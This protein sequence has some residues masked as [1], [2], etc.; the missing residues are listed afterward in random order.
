MCKTVNRKG[1]I[2]PDAALDHAEGK[3]ASAPAPAAPTSLPDSSTT[4][5]EVAKTEGG[6]AEINRRRASQLRIPGGV[7]VPGKSGLNI[8]AG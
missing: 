3:K 8:P 1:G 7:N 2:I 6:Q 4:T 5:T